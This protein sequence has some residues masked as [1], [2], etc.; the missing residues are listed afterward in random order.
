M[1]ILNTNEAKAD[2]EIISGSSNKHEE[3]KNF[4][5]TYT[6]D[7]N[8]AIHNRSKRALYDPAVSWFKN[9]FGIETKRL[10]ICND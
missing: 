9:R 10:L 1:Q 6:E 2:T 3:V 5:N 4:E 7:K 8:E